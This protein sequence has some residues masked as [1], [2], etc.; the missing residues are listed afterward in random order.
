MLLL[1]VGN[2]FIVYSCGSDFNMNWFILKLFCKI[3]PFELNMI[4]QIHTVYSTG[5][6][7]QK[8]HAN[9]PSLHVATKLLQKPKLCDE[10]QKTF[11]CA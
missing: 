8:C 9:I 6:F 7:H 11:I 5:G 3:L 2:E 10:L 1:I 4:V